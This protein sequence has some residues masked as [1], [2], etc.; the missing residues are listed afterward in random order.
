MFKIGTT[1]ITKNVI[2]RENE[3]KS[4]VKDFTIS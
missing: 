4:F 3:R 2:L 1:R